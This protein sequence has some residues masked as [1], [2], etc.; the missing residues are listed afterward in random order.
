MIRSNYTY[1]IYNGII[2]II[3]LNRGGKSVTNDIDNV[4]EDICEM[5][6]LNPNEQIV[7]YCDSDGIWDGYSYKDNHFI[8]LGCE[9]VYDALDE[10]EQTIKKQNN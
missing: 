2:S 7:V 8:F 10:I 1:A 6:S 5:E 4:I 9:N 3:D